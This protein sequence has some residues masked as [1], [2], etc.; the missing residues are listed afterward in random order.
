M[1]YFIE[2]ATYE[3]LNT[4]ETVSPPKEKKKGSR[5]DTKTHRQ[6]LMKRTSSVTY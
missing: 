5:K 6:K 3:Q 1:D 4:L 2:K